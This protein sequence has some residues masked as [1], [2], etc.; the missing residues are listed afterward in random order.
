[1][2][3]VV[4]RLD[5]PLV[6]DWNQGGVGLGQLLQLVPRWLEFGTWPRL[7]AQWASAA[8]VWRGATTRTP[9]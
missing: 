7:G 4:C 6:M 1:M 5:Y 9:V 2:D 3:V 8:A